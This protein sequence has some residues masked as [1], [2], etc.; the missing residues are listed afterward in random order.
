MTDRMAALRAELV[1]KRLSERSAE[2]TGIP[3]VDR[4][5]PLPLSFAQQRL[6][7]LEQLRPGG[8][9]YLIPLALRL[10]GPLDEVRLRAALTALVERH[11]VLRTRYVNIDN[12]PV[13]LIDEPAELPVTEVDLRGRPASTVD[14][15]LAAEGAKPFGLQAEHPLR[16]TLYRL[17]EQDNLLLL[18]VHHIAFDGWSAEV[19][20]EDLAALYRGRELAPLPVQYADFASWQRAKAGEQSGVDYWTKQLAGLSALPLLTDRPYP[21]QWNPAGSTVDFTLPAELATRL[22]ALGRRYDATPFMVLLAGIQA[23]LARHTGQ[24]DVAIGSPIAARTAPGVER[25]VGYFANTLVLRAD[26]GEDLPFHVLLEQVRETSLAAFDHAE[27]PFERLVTELA[28]ARDLSRNPL[29]QVSFAFEADATVSHDLSGLTLTEQRTPWS[30]AKFE[31]AFAIKQLADG[32]LAGHLDYATALFDESTVDRIA[33]HLIGLFEHVTEHPDTPLGALPFH[34][35]SEVDDV[36]ARNEP[37]HRQLRDLQSPARLTLDR[38][39]RNAAQER[40]DK[41]AVTFGDTEL[42]YRDLDERANHLAHELIAQGVGPGV[43]V[44]VRMRRCAE[45]VIALLAVLKA[46]GGYLP[47]DPDQPDDRL[48]FMIE[49]SGIPL[50]LTEGDVPAQ[51]STVDPGIRAGL[52]DLAY[53]I[54][55]S[56]STGKPKGVMVSHRNVVRLLTSTDPDFRF[57]ADDVWTFF[58]SYAFDFSVWEIWGALTYGA[59][60]VVVPFEISRSPKDFLNTLVDERVTILNQTPSAFTNLLGALGE[61]TPDFALRAV[62]FG[63]EALDV[64]ALGPWFARLG[65]KAPAM[66]NMY[67]ITETTVH[68]TYREVLPVDVARHGGAARSPIG[69]PLRDLELYVVDSALNPAPIGV[70]G[71]LYVGGAGLAHGYLNRP[72]LTAERFLPDPF[73]GRSGDRLYRTGDKARLLPDGEIEFLGRVDDQVKIRG[74]RIETGEVEA[75]LTTHDQVD[76]AVVV[77]HEFA[78]GDKRLVGYVVLSGTAEVAGLRTHLAGR[79]PGYMIPAVFVHLEELPLTT[80]GKVNRRAL[81]KPDVSRLDT[82]RE[83]IAPAS[84]VERELAK[85]WAEELGLE[86]V[87]GTDNFFELGGDSIRA[88]RVVGRMKELGY[89]VAVQDLFRSQ[90]IA[91]LAAVFPEATGSAEQRVAPFALLDPADRAA[92]PDEVVD[93]YPLAEGQA[94]M[95]YEML[96]DQELRPY[97]NATTYTVRDGEALDLPALR[98]AVDTIVERHEVL[99]TAFELSRFSR[100][101]QL[102][103]PHADIPVRPVD[104]RGLSTADCERLVDD[105]MRAERDELFDLTVPGTWRLRVYAEDECWRFTLVEC[106]AILD[107]WSHHSMITELLAWYRSYRDATPQP[108]AEVAATRYAD[109]IAL[110]QRALNS[111]VDREFWASRVE[112]AAKLRLPEVWADPDPG[113][114]PMYDLHVPFSHLE[115]QL[116]E[117]A[118]LAGV[119]FKSV[120]LTAHLRALSLATDQPRFLTGLISNGR[121]ET[122]DGDR[123]FGMYLNVVPFRSPEFTG[124]WLDAVR[125]VFAEEVAL[126]GHRRYPMAAMLREFGDGESLVDVGFNFLDFHVLDRDSVDVSGT[127]DH[128]PNEVGWGVSTEWGRLVLVGNARYVAKQH[129]LALARVYGAVLTAMAADPHGPVAAPVLP[130]ADRTR[131]IGGFLDTAETPRTF[132]DLVAEWAQRTPDGTALSYQDSTLSYRELID[133]VDELARELVARGI[134]RGSVVGV[135]LPQSAD[136]IVAELAVTRAG[137]AFLPLDPGQPPARLVY[138]LDDASVR[139]LIMSTQVF[140]NLGSLGRQVTLVDGH[141]VPSTVDLPE[142]LPGDAAY[143]FY[144]SGST[145]RPKGVVVEHR[146]LASMTASHSQY[147]GI[148]PGDRVLQLAA[149]IFDISIFEITLAL[150]HGATLVL[151]PR[152]QL[153]PGEPLVEL[154]RAKR[155]THMAIVPSALALIPTDGYTPRV[156]IVGGEECPP[157]LAERW[158]SIATF[159]NGYGP[160]ETTVWATV[161]RME[162]DTDR[163]TIGR[164]ILGAQAYVVDEHLEPRLP[165]VPGELVVGGIGVARGYLGRPDLTAER[166]V[167]DPFSAA[168]GARLYR[169]GDRVRLLPDGRIDFLGR[170]DSQVKI[171]GHRIELGEVEA[172][173]HEHP[174]VRQAVVTT[175][176]APSGDRQL[177]GYLVGEQADDLRVFLAERLPGYMIPASLM[178]VPELA[179]TPSGKLDRKALPEPTVD[180][181]DIRKAYLVPRTATEQLI[182]DVWEEVLGAERVGVTDDFYELGGHSLLAVRCVAVL[183]ERSGRGVTVQQLLRHRTVGELAAF[184]DHGEQAGATGSTVVWF[185][186]SGVDTPL[187]L[188]H[189]GGGSVHWYRELAALLPGE[190]PI[191]ALQHPAVIDPG[192]AATPI[193]QL[194]A[195]YLEAV[196]NVQPA[197]P[198]RL[199]GWCGGGPVTWE[200]AQLLR[201]RGAEVSVVLLDPTVDTTGGGERPELLEEFH[202]SAELLEELM[203]CTDEDRARQIRAEVAPVLRRAVDDDGGVEITE[204]TIGAEWLER[205]RLWTRLHDATLSYRYRTAGLPLTLILGDELVAEGHEAIEGLSLRSYVDRW[206]EIAGGGLHTERVSG[207]HLGVLTPPHVHRLADLLVSSWQLFLPMGS[208]NP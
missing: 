152:E 135:C 29:I 188:V 3:R 147:L 87:G 55:T 208:V 35:G 61:D 196:L 159:L 90:T 129:G 57:G 18:T 190:H 198:Y 44:G 132:Y 134:G 5:R 50:V 24:P 49:D 36:R 204:D 151:A 171:R 117:L 88:V 94:G 207:D 175:F 43:L 150:G 143:V 40:P 137:G 80:N 200:L 100:P 126:T 82:G 63:G 187:F 21:A 203:D 91:D 142:V 199:F 83:Y 62:V 205:L 85:V 118:T 158:R 114:D 109:F 149:P 177:V 102:V 71:E 127:V 39:V 2:S 79:L 6:W 26:A 125:A 170:L 105:H 178:F 46:G 97:H 122:A 182:A 98:R 128:S 202:R 133:R 41:V 157:A 101:L 168:P 75:A 54:Y 72:E 201:D 19:L 141:L 179:R 53:V 12:E 167:P 96:A 77:A 78:P 162:P 56:G 48:G 185:R 119:S 153:T 16:A 17:A 169:T 174:A 115:E 10:T 66:I 47:L 161:D 183:K 116:R 194:A 28:P 160:T 112:D 89:P 113:P 86:R 124:S 34:T 30:P 140:G 148:E 111:T 144:T 65:A 154:L 121:P 69:A 74:F 60:L 181:R 37:E 13:Q 172:A 1:R 51:R 155:I 131:L 193:E 73:S 45:L 195:I 146:G 145:G 166:F 123:T 104:L 14:A 23:L 136:L 76:A 189:P 156:V 67:G 68:V 42:S 95:I 180:T 107:G 163:F 184:L 4:G 81:P 173:L 192:A 15:L 92:L 191:A 103:Y 120:L 106:H 70:P 27:V 165:G 32:S 206:T 139:Q 164:A 108:E 84:D 31:L 22:A 38:L 93:A 11:E 9:E 130:A 58:H 138:V 186:K 52:D 8:A 197:G 110:E 7:L 25:V 59:R 99:R 176:T 20:T 64:S 33:H